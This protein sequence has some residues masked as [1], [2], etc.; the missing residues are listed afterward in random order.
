MDRRLTA[1]VPVLR[2]MASRSRRSEDLLTIAA[3]W[4]D[5][6]QAGRLLDPMP[7]RYGD[8]EGGLGPRSELMGA[9]RLFA[10]RAVGRAEAVRDRS[11]SL[12]LFA[13]A[14]EPLRTVQ[15]AD[16]E[17]IAAV[18]EQRRIVVRRMRSR[19]FSPLE[20]AAT[21]S[22]L[23]VEPVRLA[24]LYRHMERLRS[25]FRVTHPDPALLREADPAFE[26]ILRNR[27]RRT[28]FLVR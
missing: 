16:V 2:Q 28:R 26:A 9:A 22:A 20:V 21:T 5:G 8:D 14:V 12:R 15:Y 23:E 27:A 19:G 25:E 24:E 1:Y 11:L 7:A 4:R 10:N 18:D 13:A 17:T 6:R 3:V